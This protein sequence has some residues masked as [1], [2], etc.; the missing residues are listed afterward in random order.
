MRWQ[1][2]GE[3]R[4]ISLFVLGFCTTIFLLFGM[5]VGGAWARCFYALAAAYGIGFFGLAAEWFWARWYAMGL[6]G[7]GITLTILGLITSGWNLPLAI[8]G[9]IHLLIYLPL[10][11]SSMADRYE[12]QEAWRA[13]YS[14][15]EYAVTRIKRAVKGAAT[16][17]P[18]LIFFTLAPRD[19]NNLDATV[20]LPILAGLG[21][22]GML[23]MRF[24]GVA[25]LGLVTG[26][27]LISALSMPDGM[28]AF[29]QG[30]TLPGVGLVAVAA[31]SL[32]VAPFVI[33][34]YR[35][36]RAAR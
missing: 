25:L 1:L 9:G 19:G 17:L 3:R 36:L 32:A 27:T 10:L 31:L 21:L 16:A 28:I 6:A 14:I 13:K 29:S 11:G 23:R 30:V 24:W 8:W 12:Y 18:T 35:W 15:D 34:A 20:A 33:P 22:Y 26:L 4:A 5:I 2:L 7:S